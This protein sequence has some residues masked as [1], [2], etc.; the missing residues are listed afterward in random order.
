MISIIYV[1]NV[2][3]LFSYV[4]HTQIYIGLNLYIFLDITK[5]NTFYLKPL[6]RRGFFADKAFV[7]RPLPYKDGELF[8]A[9]DAEI[10]SPR[11]FPVPP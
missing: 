6:M 2:F 11:L 9:D 7:R 4:W 3:F 1:Y 10:D 5:G 8:C